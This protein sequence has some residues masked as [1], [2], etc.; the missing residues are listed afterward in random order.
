VVRR[1][2]TSAGW[3]ERTPGPRWPGGSHLPLSSR[4]HR[5]VSRT[6]LRRGGRN[7]LAIGHRAAVTYLLAGSLG[8]QVSSFVTS[9]PR[10][11]SLAGQREFL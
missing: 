10:A 2:L 6:E 8:L 9:H 3:T 1:G 11:R 5:C 7:G 4:P